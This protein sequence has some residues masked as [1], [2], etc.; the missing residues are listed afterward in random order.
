MS[1]LGR[2]HQV[3]GLALLGAVAASACSPLPDSGP[4]EVGEAPAPTVSAAP[5]DFNPPGPVAGAGR[6]EIVTGFLRAL[7]ATPVR[8]QAAEEFLTDDAA[9]AWR[10]AERTIVYSEQRVQARDDEVVVRLSATFE[11]DETGRW[12]GTG[13]GSPSGSF[14]ADGADRTLRFR[15]ARQD[16][17]W[18]I[19]HLPDA[20]VIPEPH[21]DTRYREYVLPFFDAT[22]SVVVPEQVYLPWGVQA[23]TLLV[24]ALLAGPPDAGQGVERTFF[25]PST[26]LGVGV[27]VREDGVAEVPLSRHVLDLRDEQLDLAMAQLAWT[28]GQLGEISRFAVTVDGTPIELPDGTS[29]M[30]V[31]AWPEYAPSIASA[32]TDLFGVRDGAVVQVVD[33][34][35]IEAAPLPGRLSRPRSMGVDLAGQQFALVPRS[36]TRVVLLPRAAADGE[37]APTTAYRGTDVLRPLW[38]HT[39]RLWLL[40]RGDRGTAVLVAHFGRVRRIPAPGLR[41]QEVLAASLS[42]DGTRLVVALDGDA[43]SGDDLVMMRVVRQASGAPVR[44]TPPRRLSTPQPLLG[45]RDL[46]WRDPTTIAV[47]TRPSRN[48][49]EVVLAS[50]DGS[51]GP[52]SLDSV[53]D[54]L[55]EPGLSLAASPATPPAL[56]V[57]ARD[58]GVHALDVQGRWDLD[59]VPSGLRLPAFVG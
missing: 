48:T 18:R 4:V 50:P 11:L 19:A 40:D 9:A 33:S 44:L 53:L 1:G 21:F 31:D 51:S 6:A 30:D 38:D 3:A 15:F 41:S 14:G 57:A 43:R 7:Q 49:T 17:E 29:V 36:G 47:L 54:V 12:A 27:P 13:P 2:R 59:V 35:E 46:G 24:S 39:G 52:L 32:S 34:S 58:G 37:S 25:P 56:M 42:R 16:G 55:F 28:L 45:V 10:P 5:F 26:R 22:S 8:T 20:T 23:P